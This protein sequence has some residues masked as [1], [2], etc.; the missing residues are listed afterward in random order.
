MAPNG[1]FDSGRREMMPDR[2]TERGFTLIEVLV[3]LALLA[4][5]V[6]IVAP[7]VFS[8]LDKG[9][10]TRIAGDMSS[11]GSG[12][13]AFR[14]DVTPK[15]PGDLED[16]VVEIAT[17]TDA[18]LDGG[19]YNAGQ[20]SR[21]GGPYIEV[22]D[23]ADAASTTTEAFTTGFGASVV[24]DLSCFNTASTTSANEPTSVGECGANTDW[25]AVRATGL[26]QSDFDL[27][28]AEADDGDGS[29]T[30]RFRFANGVMYFLAAQR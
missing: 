19:S 12:V 2:D 20:A 13:K 23:V 14:V 6:A 15:Y 21:W 24:S 28:D 7:T 29:D 3:V 8:Q 26:S 10:A 9:D 1:S 18:A 22:T 30:G 4:A 16:L 17:S 5:I 25:V 27:V 11:M